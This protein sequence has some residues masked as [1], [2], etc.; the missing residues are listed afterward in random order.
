MPFPGYK[1]GGVHPQTAGLRN[2]L[3]YYGTRAPHDGRPY[4]EAM[5]LGTAGGIGFSYSMRES[6]GAWPRVAL[7]FCE[8]PGE[9][10]GFFER[11]CARLRAPVTVREAAN[12][13]EAARLLREMV[14]AGRAGVVSLDVARLPYQDA[15]AEMFGP[16]LTAVVCGYEERSDAFELDDRAPVAWRVPAAMLAEARAA[17]GVEKQRLVEVEPP[18]EYPDLSAAI[19]AGIRDCVQA[20]VRPAHNG[21][22]LPGISEL[23]RLV[24]DPDDGE[25]WPTV[26]PAG[27]ALYDALTA[28]YAGVACAG[29]GGDALRSLYADFLEE[30]SEVAGRPAYGEAAALFR[31]SGKLWGQLGET[32]LPDGVGLLRKARSRMNTIRRLFEQQGQPVLPGMMATRQELNALRAEAAEAFPMSQGDID[33][34]LHALGEQLLAIHD[35]E[36]EAVNRL[37]DAVRAA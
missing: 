16:G 25:G 6:G 29:T 37:E 11:A 15:T 8:A 23:A 33:E 26:F 4:T 10:E 14:S 35:V 12:G 31:F 22:G 18:S 3:S 32:L 5:V 9:N 36:T 13:E 27:A 24:R 19:A 7:S 34:L 28:T 30:A 17:A 1:T 21:A 20:M 2:I